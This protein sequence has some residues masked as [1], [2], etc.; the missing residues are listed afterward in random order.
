VENKFHGDVAVKGRY[1]EPGAKVISRNVA[2]YKLPYLG[3]CTMGSGYIFEMNLG[4]LYKTKSMI[5][6]EVIDLFAPP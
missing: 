2:C 4:P 3:W 5:L 6:F 1:E